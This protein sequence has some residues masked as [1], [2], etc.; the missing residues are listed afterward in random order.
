MPQQSA[1]AAVGD[2]SGRG[3]RLNPIR[4]LTLA[5]AGLITGGAL[6][7]VG[8]RLTWARV[9]V[10]GSPID[11][12]GLPRVSIGDTEIR[13]D[14]SGVARGWIFGLGLLIALVA[15]TWVVLGWRGRLVTGLFAFLVAG[16]VFYVAAAQRSDVISLVQLNTGIIAGNKRISTGPGIPITAAGASL[17][18]L[19]AVWGATVGRN[20]PRL[21][22]PEKPP[23]GPEGNGKL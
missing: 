18:A 9:I 2:Q 10:R 5:G 7:A 22:L 23:G 12:P 13:Y 21:G 17:A 15:L 16:L 11:A 8:S 4:R 19:A 1:R 20:V 14:A 6:I 3:S